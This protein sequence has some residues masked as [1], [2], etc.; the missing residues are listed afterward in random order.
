MP[1]QDVTKLVQ[2]AV[3][4]DVNSFTELC[5]RFYPAMVAIAHSI[6]NDRDSAEDVAQQSFAKV[7]H[8]LPQLKNEKK[9]GSWIASI[10][11][12]AAI[13]LSRA[14]KRYN[15]VGDLSSIAEKQKPTDDVDMVKQ[16]ISQLCNNDR[17]IIYLKFYDGLSYADI[18]GVLGISKQ[19]INGKLRRAKKKL[20]LVL[21]RDG[22]N[23]V[24]S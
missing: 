15:T 1:K 13:D 10:C 2:A 9:F 24:Q 19:A 20:A 12:N 21:K 6:L 4:G 8:K 5:Q 11:R 22:F 3:D 17:E 23:E 16:A 14:N 18:S 7:V